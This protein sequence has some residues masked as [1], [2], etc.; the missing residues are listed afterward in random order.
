MS[1]GATVPATGKQPPVATPRLSASLSA[2]LSPTASYSRHVSDQQRLRAASGPRY[3]DSALLSPLVGGTLSATVGATMG[4][5]TK[6]RAFSTSSTGATARSTSTATTVA[7]TAAAA[8]TR[9]VGKTK[10]RTGTGMTYRNTASYTELGQTRSRTPVA[11]GNT[12]AVVGMSTSSSFSS[13]SG[14]SRKVALVV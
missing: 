13:N 5:K 8:A 9:S 1:A 11:S 12:G 7:A 10:P 14:I 6:T 4:A 2:P 3:S